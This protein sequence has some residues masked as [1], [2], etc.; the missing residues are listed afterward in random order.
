ML[1]GFKYYGVYY[2]IINIIGVSIIPSMQNV[3]IC[4]VNNVT[5]VF[6]NISK[7]VDKINNVE[8]A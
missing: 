4:I 8:E 7:C 2:Y 6:F 3:C 1:V 5:V